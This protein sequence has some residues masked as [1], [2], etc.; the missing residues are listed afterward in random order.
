M[1]DG[2]KA[3]WKVV[4]TDSYTDVDGEIFTADE[5]TGEC[6]VRVG[7]ETKTF[8]FGTCGIR[9]VPRRR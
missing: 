2:Q 5:A 6:C 9:I 8:S 1:T 3:P 4:R 7:G